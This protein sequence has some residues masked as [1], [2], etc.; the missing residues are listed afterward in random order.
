MTKKNLT[1]LFRSRLSA[2]AIVAGPLVLILLV[3]LAFSNT[4][5]RGIGIGV[6]APGTSASVDKV[7]ESLEGGDAFVIERHEM[8]ESCISSVKEGKSHAC[9]FLL[10]REEQQ[11][12]VVFHVDYSRL[13]L[14]WMLLNAIDARIADQSSMIGTQLSEE[15]LGRLRKVNAFVDTSEDEVAGLQDASTG[16]KAR[17]SSLRDSVAALDLSGPDP[18][19]IG[20]VASEAEEQ[21]T[22]VEDQQRAIDL[23]VADARDELASSREE[24]LSARNDLERTQENLDDW[25]LQLRIGEG[26]LG[27]AQQ[28]LVDLSQHIDDEARF[29]EELESLARPD[30]GLIHT[31]RK[32]ME[33][34][35]EDAEL[36]AG[37]LDEG[38]AQIDAADRQ[39]SEFKSASGEGSEETISRIR[40]I[41]TQLEQVDSDIRAGASRLEE[42]RRLRQELLM[43]L[44]T[45]EDDISASEQAFEDIRSSMSGVRTLLEGT[46]QVTPEA[47]IR[48]I[49]TDVQSVTETT[50]QLDFIFPSLLVLIVM[51]VSVLGASTVVMKEKTSKAYFRNFITPSA[52]VLSFTGVVLS[53]AVLALIQIGI[54]ALIAW[55]FFG[56]S[57]LSH[58][59]SL[60][61]SLILGI[62][63]FSTLG[64]LFGY[65][66]NSEE[67]TTLISLIVCVILFIFSNVMIPIES[68]GPMF[69]NFAQANPFVLLETIIKDATLFS[70]SL[71]GLPLLFLALE[72][73]ALLA[74]SWYA[75]RR[76]REVA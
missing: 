18:Q 62:V 16:L 35:Q 3:G 54:I 36:L 46:S 13:S 19:G 17:I 58:P 7:I 44:G 55:L 57:V 76:A 27:C 70:G 53:T 6:Y 49:S 52:M 64:M 33:R 9:L 63:F 50:E 28:D 51:F 39:L 66:F 42:A 71:L 22:L 15:L 32:Q 59:I 29:Q 1:R 56:I 47:I 75:V 14:V 25:V 60:S 74:I 40:E 68:M 38:I 2:A 72:L 48:P 20:D 21:V 31:T 73:A 67:T 37:R 45:V 8:N 12:D 4:G 24:L 43:Q 69:R 10:P 11:V 26:T 23:Q 34:S 30:C 65:L 41:A 5:L 61:I